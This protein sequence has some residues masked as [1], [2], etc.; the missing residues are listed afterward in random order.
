MVEGL[1][2]FVEETNVNFRQPAVP[3]HGVRVAPKGAHDY[4]KAVVEVPHAAGH[5]LACVWGDAV[6]CC[7]HNNVPAGSSQTKH[8]GFD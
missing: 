3:S 6:H 1:N 2:K 7:C 4:R 5:A 8:V